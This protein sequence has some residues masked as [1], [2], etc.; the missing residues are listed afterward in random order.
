MERV[1]KISK[2]ILLAVGILFFGELAYSQEDQ[3]LQAKW[4][5][6]RIQSEQN[7]LGRMNLL[8]LSKPLSTY[9]FPFLKEQGGLTLED[10]YFSK[11]QYLDEAGHP[12]IYAPHN[13]NAAITTG[14]N[15]LQPG[16]SLDLNLTGKGLVVGIFD[17]TRP[18][19]DHPE[20]GTRLTQVDGSTE[21]LSE[22][23]THVTG[24]IMASGINSGVRGM[25][26]EATG[27]AFNWEA[28]I[29]KM[30]ANAY[31]PSSKPSGMLIS[32][33]SYG[34][35]L[36]WRRDNATTWT[37]FG[38]PSISTEEDWRFGFYS[39]KSQAIDDLIYSRPY[40]SVVWSAG[41]D[42]DD[43]G[44]GTRPPDGPE[45]TIGPEGVA[46]NN[47]TVGAVSQVLDYTGP[48]SVSIG[49][50]SSWGPTD[51]G[52]I[53]PDLVGMGV[54]VFSSSINASNQDSYASLSGTSMS[55]PNVT[56]SLF[57]LQQLY[58]QRNPGKFMLASTLK[59]LAIHT[60]KE[61]GPAPG[62]DYMYGWGLLDAKASADLILNEDGSS[63]LIRE[64]ILD[65]GATYQYEFVSD[66]IT[67]IS[68]TIAWTDPAGNPTGSAVD[69][70]NLMLVNDLDL[71]IFDEDGVE[72]FPWTLNPALGSSAR[73][74]QNTDNF[75]D[76]VEKVLISSPAPK[77]YIVKV[78]HKGELTFGMQ[79]F[80]LVFTG[81]AVDGAEETLY[82]IGG[83]TGDWSDPTKWS[84]T[85][86]G[87]SVGKIPGAGTRVVFDGPSG[88]NKTVNLTASSNAFSI[89][90]FGD[91]L[92]SLDLK[93]Q[94]LMVSNGFRIS[95]QITEI[96]NGS[97][98]FDS[99]SSNELLVE[100]GQT[101]FE[102]TALEFNGGNWRVISG[103]KLDELLV[104]S[105][106]VNFDMAVLEAKK[107]QVL[108]G[109]I[110]DG[111]FEV[112]KF[113]ESVT[114]NSGGQLKAGLIA[115]FDGSAGQ[116]SNASSN[117]FSKL[118]VLSGILQ[119]ASDG[120]D[121]LEIADGKAV[122]GSATVNVETLELGE[123]SILEFAQMGTFTVLDA[124]T[125]T[126]TAQSKALISA[127]NGGST[128]SFD[129]YKKL[130]FDHLNVTNVNKSGQG[131]INLGTAA[132]IQNATGWLS[133]DCDE[134]LFA[135]F[136]STFTCVGAAVDFEN[137][138][139]GAVSAYLWEFK[140]GVTSTLENPIFVF[141]SPGSYPVKL[142][143]SNSMGSTSFVEEIEITANDLAKP[144]IV[145][146]G[147][148]LTSQQPGASY[149]WYQNGQPITG[150]N[151]RSFVAEGDG[152]YQVAIFDASCNRLSDPVIISAL[153][154]VDLSRFGIFVGPVPSYD[155]V[156]IKISNEYKG[157]IS[158]SILD[159]TGRVYMI[160]SAG[161]NSQD[162]TEIITLPSQTGL[163]ILRIETKALTLHKKLIKY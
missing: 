111:D 42:R 68:A 120:I 123:G 1:L 36:G 63:K 14:V 132:T 56:G 135:K 162:F 138:S 124:I 159:M 82:W 53:K 99:E 11:I 21:T 92:L 125:S 79:P 122:L 96:K 102:N 86:N 152:S 89:N 58:G 142:T 51:D 151:D 109:G 158:F 17:Q 59:A 85:A 83:A 97:I 61:A 15:H 49:A 64:L 113:S 112:L 104:S 139:E 163:Y 74:A 45:D 88:Q 110:L 93:S 114:V 54:N 136:Q 107:I 127:V 33:H 13:V 43:V 73:G 35:V 87:P 130:C 98:V 8:R 18:K 48:N 91:Q 149:Q 108:A 147:S 4:E 10:G 103:S 40:Y 160:R 5:K 105:S 7:L 134:V 22:H 65:Q 129:T 137:Q 57:L 78:T 23:S 28:D 154:E 71:R 34:V 100:F 126:A 77:K 117:P 16:G 150:A 26:Y 52:R 133:Q 90:V 38:N 116:F 46:K 27:W 69:P 67:Q 47:I 101:L 2:F 106:K 50:F 37:W 44:N 81:G 143:I 94:S 41:N 9:S 153:P 62:P 145:I 60:A 6:A 30:L 118:E 144:I 76:N 19:R 24:T 80:S 70:T 75:R 32:N 146:N 31:E 20:F 119:L 66:G 131:I 141:D 25:A 72:F 84:L 115:R 148:Q 95:N 121:N 156:T 161:K 155:Q 55:A 3:S 39:S 12:V 29:S 140:P 128:L 157:P